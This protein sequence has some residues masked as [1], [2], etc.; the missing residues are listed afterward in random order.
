MW[1]KKAL[2]PNQ[3]NAVGTTAKI[4]LESKV[5]LI[6]EVLEAVMEERNVDD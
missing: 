2:T 5:D 1:V 4:T 6:E 3:E